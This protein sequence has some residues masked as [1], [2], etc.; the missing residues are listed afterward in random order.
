[1]RFHGLAAA[2][3]AGVWAVATLAS[4]QPA[5]PPAPAPTAA[6]PTAPPEAP[7]VAAGTPVI[8]EIA[9]P[10]SSKRVKRGDVFAIR[11]AS[12][13]LL[14]G[15]VRVPAGIVGRGEVIDAAAAGPLGR[16]AK[17]LLAARYLEVDGARLPLRGFNLGTAGRDNTNTIL[18]ASFVPYGG[19]CAGL[20]RGG[21][22]G[23]PAGSLGRAKPAA[24]LAAQGVVAPRAP[25][26]P[27]ATPT[28]QPSER[29]AQ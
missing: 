13:I 11:L 29:N 6:P 26:P 18:A 14:D 9:E 3:S 25:P 20:M 8:I 19:I 10:I 1:M 4:T 23:V 15:Q 17:L 12:P 7:K 22:P 21:E 16:P 24:D 2:L 27:P 5:P 28:S